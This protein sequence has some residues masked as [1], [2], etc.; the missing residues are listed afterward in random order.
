[1]KF[2]LLYSNEHSGSI[3][4][5]FVIQ[6]YQVQIHHEQPGDAGQDSPEGPGCGQLEACY[7]LQGFQH[8]TNENQ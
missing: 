5:G 2:D 7:C 8:H 3:E 6:V 4:P 1:M